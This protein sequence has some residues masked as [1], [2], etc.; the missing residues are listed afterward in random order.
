MF[1]PKGLHSAVVMPTPQGKGG[2]PAQEGEEQT[3][4]PVA[5]RDP[6]P[7]PPT[8]PSEPPRIRMRRSM[9]L[10]GWSIPPKVLLVDDDAVCRKLSSK[11]LQVFGCFI[12]IAVDGVGA[13]AKMNLGKYDLVFM[14]CFTFERHEL[15][16]IIKCRTLSCPNSMECLRLRKS[17]NLTP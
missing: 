17:A 1:D 4:E 14:V 3:Q 2:D 6:T 16:L 13:V 9:Y 15:L 11:F 7:S 5:L 10:P 8:S 12:D